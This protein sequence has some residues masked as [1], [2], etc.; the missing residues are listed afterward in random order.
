MGH[1]R[2]AN[3]TAA[4]LWHRYS[5]T[6]DALV[7]AEAEPDDLRDALRIAAADNRRLGEEV[8]M[9][10]DSQEPPALQTMPTT[11]RV[12]EVLTALHPD[13]G[14]RWV[15]MYGGK[16]IAAS[17][18]HVPLEILAVRKAVYASA[19]LLVQKMAGDCSPEERIRADQWEED[20]RR[21]ADL[22][23]Q[24]GGR[25]VRALRIPARLSCGHIRMVKPN[26]QVG[27][28]QVNCGPC[29]AHRTVAEFVDSGL[30][31]G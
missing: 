7:L 18:H 14:W 8:T 11:R 3:T 17:G 19:R 31:G 13:K 25:K 27:A 22:A 12:I 21:L 4:D 30:I 23:S 9:L 5:T 26:T 29:A 20:A 2:V 6:G 15:V 28:D 10:L 24:A 1:R 16:R